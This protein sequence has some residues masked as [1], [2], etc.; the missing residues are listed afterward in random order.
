MTTEWPWLAR[1]HL[2]YIGGGLLISLF[3]WFRF[4][5]L[6]GTR[7]YTRAVLYY[8]GVICFIFPFVTLYV[9]VAEFV[10]PMS[11]VWILVG[12]WLLPWIPSFWRDFC[13]RMVGIPAYAYRL[14]EILA[15]A[16]F[17]ILEDDTAIVQRKLA[18]IGFSTDDFGAVQATVIQ[19]RFLKITAIMHHLEKW[20]HQYR[21]FMQRNSEA[22][23]S[24]LQTFDLLSFKIIR[25]VKSMTRINS[26][27]MEEVGRSRSQSDDWHTLNTL[28]ISAKSEPLYRLQS[29]AQTAVGT[30]MEDLRKDID[31]FLDR[32]LLFV[33]RG[34]L[35]NE[36][37]FSRRR[38][39]LEAIGFK[40]VQP[41]PSIIPSVL[42]A[43]VIVIVCSLIWFSIVGISTSGSPSIAFVKLL[44]VSSL[45]VLCNF[46][47][48]Y[49]LKRRYAFANPR[50]FGGM[51]ITFILTVGF[52]A[53]L[54]ILPVRI[55]FEYF[56]LRAQH[57]DSVST[58]ILLARNSL[59][60]FM[61]W[62]WATGA[63][64]A[65]LAQ[66]SM[67]DSISS[68]RQKRT[69][70]GLVFGTSWTVAFLVIWATNHWG[71]HVQA[72]D[73]LPF[74]MTLTFTFGV[75]FL[76]GFFALA[77]I[78]DG[79]SFRTPITRDVPTGTLSYAR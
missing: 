19:A 25:A 12:V 28:A 3:Y 58:F 31:L 61:L 77:K 39:Q 62:V 46:L 68:Q 40:I 70:D 66:D 18:R 74:A 15:I 42:T 49:H 76:L 41:P 59:I 67:W 78:R 56:E 23:G 75:G 51:P 72:I 20:E 29:A 22:Y 4:H 13:H 16:P 48:V 64:T 65:L 27:I 34:V 21:T 60:F 55:A 7:S 79:S 47:L 45:N 44:V 73:K 71:F 24:L 38:R 8:S 54:L 63:I 5:S 30:M 43:V 35:S 37:S 17:E 10:S 9:V 69:L 14:K 1:D 52:A 11:A 33:V 53:I 36:W 6:K 2:D 26:A 57:R 32:L 50:I